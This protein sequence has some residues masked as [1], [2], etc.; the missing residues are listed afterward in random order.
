MEHK[1]EWNDE[2]EKQ[3][4][5]DGLSAL[6]SHQTNGVSGGGA[7]IEQEQKMQKMKSQLD[8]MIETIRGRDFSTV[9]ALIQK[10]GHPFSV[11]VMVCPFPKK[12]RIP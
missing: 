8:I 1:G 7:T 9:K 11:V 12:F 3:A 4:D 5:N 10:T 6:A 2:Q